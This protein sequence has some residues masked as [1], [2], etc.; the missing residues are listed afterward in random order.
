MINNRLFLFALILPTLSIAV[1]LGA[2][3]PKANALSVVKDSFYFMKDDG[4][5]SDAEKDEEAQYVFEECEKNN[6]RGTYYNCVC[7]AGSFRL[8]RD[9]DEKLRP[10][11]KILT[12]IYESPTRDCINTPTIAGANFNFCLNYANSFRAR[13]NNNDEFCKCVGNDV[14]RAF[15]ADPRL[16]TKHIENLRT[17]ALMSCGR[18]FPARKYY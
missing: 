9:N 11:Q 4:E 7:V 17:G 3:T 1:F 2:P 13:E 12:E 16:R 15:T 10:Q 5:F 14:A 8:A 18:K 6:L